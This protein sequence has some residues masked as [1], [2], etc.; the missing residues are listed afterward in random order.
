MNF[1]SNKTWHIIS[2]DGYIFDLILIFLFIKCFFS[3]APREFLFLHNCTR[4]LFSHLTHYR[5]NNPWV[6]LFL[7]GRSTSAC[8]SKIISVN[9]LPSSNSVAHFSFKD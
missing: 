4:L 7:R 2:T 5:K 6:L 9:N 3:H 1:D 8:N